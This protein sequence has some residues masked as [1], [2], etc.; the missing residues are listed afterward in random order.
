VT[1]RLL[2]ELGLPFG[3]RSL[4]LDANDEEAALVKALLD[5]QRARGPTELRAAS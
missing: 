5:R 3:L 4:E 1:D 2:E